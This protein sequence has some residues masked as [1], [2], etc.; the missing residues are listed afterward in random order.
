L[1]IGARALAL[2]GSLVEVAEIVL[3]SDTLLMLVTASGDRLG[4]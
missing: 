4:E 1:N 3:G 2:D